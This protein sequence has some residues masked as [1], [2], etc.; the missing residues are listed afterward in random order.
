MAGFQYTVSVL[1]IGA[2]QSQYIQ[3]IVAASIH[4]L[5]KNMYAMR[6][7]EVVQIGVCQ[8]PLTF[9]KNVD[10]LQLRQ[11]QSRVDVRHT[12]IIGYLVVHKLQAWGSFAVVV[13]C[14]TF[15]AKA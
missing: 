9:Q 2:V 3:P 12:V 14:L 10:L 8:S 1:H 11:T 5:F 13:I 7:F 4:G 15:L 6:L